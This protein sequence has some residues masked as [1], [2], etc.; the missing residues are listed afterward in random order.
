MF[1]KADKIISSITNFFLDNPFGNNQK[2]L[3]DL[4]RFD[5]IFI[6]NGIIKDDKSKFLNKQSR[7]IKLFV[8]ILY[9]Q[10]MDIIKIT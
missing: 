3:R 10:I 1:L 5:L 8:N 4:Y 6:E 2:Y 9:H 7:N